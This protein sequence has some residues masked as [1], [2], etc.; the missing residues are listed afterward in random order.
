MPLSAAQTSAAVDGCGQTECFL[1]RMRQ[2]KDP[3]SSSSTQKFVVLR[4]VAGCC[5]MNS[6]LLLELCNRTNGDRSADSRRGHM[7]CVLCGTS[8]ARCQSGGSLCCYGQS[9][10]SRPHPVVMAT[11]NPTSEEIKESA[12]LIAVILQKLPVSVSHG[13]R[14]LS[15]PCVT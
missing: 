7:L 11:H 1:L 4:V 2:Q 5:R 9:N 8:A 12:R 13:L 15:Q 10:L 6:L 3:P 14:L